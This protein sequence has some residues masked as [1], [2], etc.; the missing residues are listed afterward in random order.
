MTT[1]AREVSQCRATVTSARLSARAWRLR[2][3]NHVYPDN[4]RAKPP[5][6]TP[7]QSLIPTS[8]V[9]GQSLIVSGRQSGSIL[10]AG[11]GL[12]ARPRSQQGPTART[13]QYVQTEAASIPTQRDARRSCTE[14]AL[15]V[16]VL[17][18]ATFCGLSDSCDPGV[19]LRRIGPLESP[20][21]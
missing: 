16:P 7:I 21:R 20:P 10:T 13:C 5:I 18:A 14:P 9:D 11:S 17:A 6:T 8:V 19:G 4:A 15:A 2:W 1:L 12:R 3:A